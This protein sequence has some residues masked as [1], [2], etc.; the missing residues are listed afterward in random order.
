M[1]PE[2]RKQLESCETLPSPPGVATQI[3]NLANDPKAEISEIAKILAMDPAITTKI[4]RIANSAMYAQSRQ[5]ENLRQAVVTLGLN[6][7]ISL[8]LSFSLLNSWRDEEP[9]GGLDY[10]LFWRRAL[11]AAAVSPVLAD[12]AGSTDR[13]EI[14]LTSLIQDIGMLALD[15]SVPGIYKGLGQRQT[16]QEAIIAAEQQKLGIDHAEVGGWLLDRWHFPQRI[17]EAV[18]A[19][20]EPQRLSADHKNALFVRCVALTSLIAEVYLDKAEERGFQMLADAAH[21]QLGMD[22]DRLGQ[23]LQDVSSLIPEAEEVFETKILVDCSAESVLEQA[24]EALMLRNLQALQVVENLQD[25]AQSLELRSLE[26]EESSRRD[27][28][29]GLYNRQYLDRFLADAF[30]QSNDTQQPL[31]V[32]FADLDKFKRVNDRHGHQVGDR[33]LAVT[34]EILSANA[35]TSDMVA[36]YGGEEF[37]IVFPNTDHDAIEAIC[38]RIVDAFRQTR[39][40]TGAAGDLTVT[41]SIGMVTHGAR[42]SF[43]TSD[44]LV[45]AADKALYFAKSMGRDRSIAYDQIAQLKSAQR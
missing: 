42:H 3:I 4:L 45:K 6:A 36:R 37:M 21:Q 12:A 33:V 20:H 28:L 19:S 5:I 44:E 8:A 18:A 9:E 24:R 29:T 41:V 16:Y 25:E 38:Q 2:L 13:E 17:Q 22:K 30:Q 7:T 11:L 26:L 27:A 32:A 14:F 43:A 31:S 23:L 39:H 34:A 40:D 1:T 10:P 15:R 35:R